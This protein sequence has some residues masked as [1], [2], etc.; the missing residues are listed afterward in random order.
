MANAGQRVWLKR[1]EVRGTGAFPIDM[2]RYDNCWPASE[3]D[4]MT[5]IRSFRLRGSGEAWSI[6]LM[7]AKGDRLLEPEYNRWA[8]FGWAVMEVQH[9]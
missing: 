5:I 3:R 9:V 1:F 2:L 6:H 8:S 4:S 7:T